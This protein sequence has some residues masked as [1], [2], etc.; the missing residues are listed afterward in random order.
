MLRAAG[1]E[2]VAP[3][4]NGLPT[5]EAHGFPVEYGPEA[6]SVDWPAATAAAGETHAH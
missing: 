4:A 6:G 2:D 5:W 1:F 3:V